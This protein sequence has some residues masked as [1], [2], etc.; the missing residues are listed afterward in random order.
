MSFRSTL[1]RLTDFGK[2]RALRRRLD[3]EL[4]FH[5]EELISEH[6]RRGLSPAAARRAA[7]RDLGNRTLTRESYR[8][9]AGLPWLEELWRDTTM[10][11]RNLS[12]RRGYALSMIGLLGVGLAATLSVYVLTDAMLRRALPVPHPDELHLVADT[13]GRPYWFSRATVDRLRENLPACP[14][15]AYGGDSN[16]TA[17]RGRQPAKSLRGQLVSGGAFVGLELVPASGRLLSAG[18]DRIGEGAPVAVAS[19]V[20][21]ERE[22][23]SAAAAVGEEIL[24]NQATVEIVGVL[25]ERFNG[26]DAVER[27]DLFFPA[28]LQQYLSIFSNSS[29]FASDDRPNDPDRNRENRVRWL[30]VLVRVPEHVSAD[31]VLPAVQVAVAPDHEDLL[32]QMQSP[33]EREELRRTTWQI[34]AAPG[35]YSNGRNAF[36]ATGRMLTGLV[37][38]LLLLT[39]AN[40]SGIMLVR[41]LSRHREMGVR[42]SLGAGRWRTCRLAMVEAVVCGVAGAGLGLVLA[43]WMVP[44]A[45]GLLTPGAELRLDILGWSQIAVLAGVALAASVGCALAPAWWISRLQP[46][47]ALSGAMGGGAMPQRVGRA[48]VALQLALAVMLVAVSLSLGREIA[49]VLQRDPGFERDRVLTSRFNPHT[50]GYSGESMEALFERIRGTVRAVPGVEEV[51]FSATGIL[52]GSRSR[53]GVFPRGE[54]LASQGGDFQVDT[55]DRA[56]LDAVG[57]RLR[58]GRWFEQTD[59]ADSPPVAVVTQAFAEAMWGRTEVLG[60]R[61]GYNYEA[62]EEDM[63]VVGIVGDAGINR[64]RESVTEMFFTPASQSHPS[65]GFLA[66]RVQRDPDVVRRMLV[67]AL[68]AAEPGLVFGSWQ[69]LGERRQSNMRSEIASSRLAT[70]IAGVAML[71]ATF[72]VGGS[73]AHLVTLRQR[74]LAVR[75]ALGASPRRLLRGVLTDGLRLGVWG[76]VGGGALVALIAWGVPFVNW[77]DASPS[78]TVGVSAAACGVA[79]A[80]IGGWLP[81][82]RAAKVDPQRM[83]KMD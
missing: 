24:I 67:T 60:E 81:A 13:E 46:L 37:A 31:S 9:Q 77:W 39:C 17:Q 26:F 43:I 75:A 21:A 50:A 47:V 79:A 32:S 66:V 7:Q 40:L 48:L 30:E 35:G 11:V 44:A 71:L 19:F 65:F 78:G 64:A 80:L 57:L 18:D 59:T 62:S 72:G 51:G 33:D 58:Q 55:V 2:R 41:T 34:L 36:A 45:A 20:W 73:L 3:E 54:G 49:E 27:V 15:I 56:Y 10:A 1:N 22:Y 28:A 4:A 53:S 82:R 38:S 63:T 12:H 69:T 83:L 74:E 25:P 52:A 5:L 8:E 6:E 29:V 42:L 70:I 68:E 14:V 61:F 23:G 76:A 16:V